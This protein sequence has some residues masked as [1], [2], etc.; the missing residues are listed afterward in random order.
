[1]NS[2]QTAILIAIL[3]SAVSVL[4]DYFLKLASQKEVALNSWLFLGGLSYALTAIGWVFVFRHLTFAQVGVVYSVSN[5]LL[6]ALVGVV[7]LG[8]TLRPIEAVSIGLG[9][10]SI[11]I[12]V[13]FA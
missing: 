6:L 5:V 1:M 9:I 12:L 8:E 7:V 2:Q 10:V 11:V 4:A 13:R 3:L